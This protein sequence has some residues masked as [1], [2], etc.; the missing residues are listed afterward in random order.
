M[1]QRRLCRYNRGCSAIQQRRLCD[2]TE[3]ALW[4]NRGGSAD[5]TEEALWY[6][7]GGSADTTQDALHIQHWGQCR[8]NTPDSAIQ[9]RKPCLVNF[10]IRSLYSL[11]RVPSTHRY[12]HKTGG[13]EGIT[14]RQ[15][16]YPFSGCASRGSHLTGIQRL[17]ENFLVYLKT[18]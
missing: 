8:Y 10:T 11:K 4:Y 14:Q 15:F 9:H 12:S 18:L 3:D 13:I 2:T 16:C 17:T 5:T 1:Q 6:N 7:R